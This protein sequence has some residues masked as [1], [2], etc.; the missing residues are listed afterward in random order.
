MLAIVN[1]KR[2]VLNLS[3][4]IKADKNFYFIAVTGGA[5]F[6]TTLCIGLIDFK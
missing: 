6:G 4:N 2:G 3:F 1:K 5:A